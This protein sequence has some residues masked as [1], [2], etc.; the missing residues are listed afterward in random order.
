VSRPSSSGYAQRLAA[1]QGTGWKRWVPNPYR[2]YLRHLELGKVLEVGCG[3][4]RNLGYL[5][6]AGL[7]I[8][9]DTDAVAI[10]RERGLTA[11]TPDEFEA[12]PASFDAL[13]LSHVVEHTAP[14]DALALVRRYLPFI[15]PG[16]RVVIITPQERGF[17]SDPT[18]VTF[19]DLADTARLCTNADLRV[20]RQQSFPLPRAFGR[21]FVYNEFITIARVP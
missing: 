14:D 13:L 18:H 5:E 12:A 3:V 20:E 9:P 2:W 11:F 6:G 21:A 7:G 16:G 8:D 4:G 10:C 15:R 17:A 19:T 1:R